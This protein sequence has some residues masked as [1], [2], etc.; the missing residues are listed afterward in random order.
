MSL[1]PNDKYHESVLSMLKD[2][3]SVF[4]FFILIVR[5]VG[6]KSGLN[7]RAN[8]QSLSGSDY[9]RQRTDLRLQATSLPLRYHR[10]TNNDCTISDSIT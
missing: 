4:R 7:Q 8:L 9:H 5:N 2:E 3:L 6:Q 10:T 1:F